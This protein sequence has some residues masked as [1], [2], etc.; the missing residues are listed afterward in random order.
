M[1][2][3]RDTAS[4]FLRSLTSL[5][6]SLCKTI[7]TSGTIWRIPLAKPFRARNL[8]HRK[9]ADTTSLPFLTSHYDARTG[10]SSREDFRY[11]DIY[12][13]KHISNLKSKAERHFYHR[14]PPNLASRQFET[15]SL[16][17]KIREN[18]LN[19]HSWSNSQ[20]YDSYSIKRKIFPRYK[21]K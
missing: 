13:I 19:G 20:H 16:I 14:I 2:G 9:E 18:F 12:K 11:I 17:K 10:N 4:D 15:S 5:L 3:S 8:N 21:I 6:V 7:R 1:Y